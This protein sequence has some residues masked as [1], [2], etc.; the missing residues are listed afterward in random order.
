M[1]YSFRRQFGLVRHWEQKYEGYP[2]SKDTTRAGFFILVS[3]ADRH[4]IL[5]F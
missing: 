1:G 5:T 4:K 2:E 3:N